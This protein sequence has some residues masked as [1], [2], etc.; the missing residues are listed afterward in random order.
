[1]G[2]RQDG[3]SAQI[4]NSIS[5]FYKTAHEYLNA[6]AHIMARAGGSHAMGLAR[7]NSVMNHKK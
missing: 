4:V 2:L 6:A 1:M 5:E 3:G 7:M